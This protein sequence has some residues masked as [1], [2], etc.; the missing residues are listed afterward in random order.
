MTA[1]QQDA[2]VEAVA[3]A[4]YD[5]THAGLSNCYAW[6]DRWEDYQESR[7]PRYYKEARAAI[8]ALS[9][10][11]FP[12]QAV[13][14]GEVARL[15]E[16]LTPFAALGEMLGGMFGTALFKDADVVPFADT[17]SENGETRTISYGDLRRAYAVWSNDKE[18]R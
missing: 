6:D 15:R 5:A 10:A 3:R 14:T 17:W 4:I 12:P 7:R 18:A 2:L 9:T 1:T 16:A 11:S 13:D 8:A